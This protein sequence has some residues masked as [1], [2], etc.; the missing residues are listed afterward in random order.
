MSD[1]HYDIK[2]ALD[3]LYVG[4]AKRAVETL[5]AAEGYK[6]P[7]KEWIDDQKVYRKASGCNVVE[8]SPL[9]THPGRGVYLVRQNTDQLAGRYFVRA[10]VAAMG[11]KAAVRKVVTILN[12][13][14]ADV[15]IQRDRLRADK[16]GD[17][18]VMSLPP[19]GDNDKGG[20][21]DFY[22]IQFGEGPT[23]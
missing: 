17:L 7:L 8:P 19:N 2:V 13:S 4:D 3:L 15:V 21:N 22:S 18:A 5:L 10:V 23:S 11:E 9:L 12:K 1:P 6:G 16:I 20:D 14:F